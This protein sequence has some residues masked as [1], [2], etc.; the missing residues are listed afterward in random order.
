VPPGGTTPE[1]VHFTVPEPAGQIQ[2][3]AFTAEV[4]SPFGIVSVSVIPLA[5]PSIAEWLTAKLTD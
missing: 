1:K 5:K 3:P 2:P 4:V